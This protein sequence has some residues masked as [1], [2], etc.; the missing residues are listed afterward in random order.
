MSD[1]PSPQIWSVAIGLAKLQGD[2]NQIY[3]RFS[4][5][6]EG[7]K[8]LNGIPESKRLAAEVLTAA[9]TDD[10]PSLTGTLKELAETLKKQYNV[11]DDLAI[12]TA[13]ILMAGKRFDGT[14]PL[15][16]FTTFTNFTKSQ[17][18][19]AILAIN[20]IPSDQ[21]VS[22]FQSFKAMFM[23]WAYDTSE[24]TEL[25]AAYLAVG[26]LG[27]EDV[28]FKMTTIISQIRNYLEY[29]LVPAAILTSISTLE[30]NEALELMEKA[31]NILK[32]VAVNLSQAELVSLA[33]RMIHGIRTETVKELDPTS[34]VTNTP[35]QFTYRPY[36]IFFPYYYYFLFVHSAY[37]S[38][39]RGVGGS[40][41]AHVHGVGGMG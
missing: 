37:Y 21:L 34:K 28:R 4:A 38:T 8:N 35:V 24:D 15:D 27:P 13:A 22:K 17:S 39:Y 19:A 41:P 5:A 11:S 18:A 23:G 12:G 7:V 33:I 9:C 14:Y 6:F 2:A 20:N 29:P 16:R 10:I 36:P 32:T 31:A 30:A 26:E 25:A 1:T 40:H 3:Q